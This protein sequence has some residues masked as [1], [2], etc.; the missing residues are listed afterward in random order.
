VSGFRAL[1]D[2]NVLYPDV[3]RD[4]LVRLARHG[5]YR[6]L[7]S[8]DILAE[9]GR[10][11]GEN[12]AVS[13]IPRLL[14]LMRAALPD[15]I[16]ECYADLVATLTLPDPD[17]RHVLAAAIVSNAAVIVSC[18]ERDF[19]A[20]ALASYGLECQHPDTFLTHAYHYDA[21]AFTAAV[22]EQRAAWRNPSVDV[23]ALFDRYRTL[24]LAQVVALLEP[25][26]S[27]L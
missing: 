11:L 8:E 17:D 24:G 19:P 16:V 20:A 23:D 4:L 6:A 13:D 1:L 7:W 22:R 26:R 10:A 25:H 12:A 15:A 9:V 3:L 5:V 27:T 18:N 21:V 2:A 14:A